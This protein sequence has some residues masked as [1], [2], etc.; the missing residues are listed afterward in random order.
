MRWPAHL[1]SLY[2]RA[3]PR[4]LLDDALFFLDAVPVWLARRMILTMAGRARRDRLRA[5]ARAPDH[6]GWPGTAVWLLAWAAVVAAVAHL[7]L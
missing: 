5:E 2:E 7:L 4:E 6:S 3:P 1:L